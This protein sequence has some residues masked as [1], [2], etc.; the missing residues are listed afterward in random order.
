MG[1]AT[2]VDASFEDK[3]VSSLTMSSF[4]FSSETSRCT[5]VVKMVAAISGRCIYSR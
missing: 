3:I 4:N 5:H 1:K 2:G